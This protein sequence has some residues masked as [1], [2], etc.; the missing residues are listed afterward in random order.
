MG[1]VSRI[2]YPGAYYHLFNRG[3][4]KQAIFWD[5]Q[6]R[7]VFFK[8]LSKTVQQHEIKLFSYCLMS[9]HFHLFIQTPQPNLDKF[10][11]SLCRLY[12][13]YINYRYERV[14]P[15]FQSRYQARVVDQERYAM[16]L[17]R[18]IHQNPVLAHLVKSPS[19]Y[20]WSSYGCY[21]KRLSRLPWVDTSFGLNFFGDKDDQF[22]IDLFVRFHGESISMQEQ[23]TLEDW[24][25]PT[26]GEVST[27]S[28]QVR[29]GR[30]G[31][32]THR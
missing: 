1:R 9:N 20:P 12:V 3:V 2:I 24:N 30:P 18:Y 26:L 14:G 17:I 22:T 10:M 32:I 11:H 25:N 15:L 23:K 4:N 19:D 21:V 13:T 31:T 6:D 8:Y 5:D 16:A 7:R 28:D 29:P 27:G